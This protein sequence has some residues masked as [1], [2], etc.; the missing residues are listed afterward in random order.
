MAYPERYFTAMNE[1]L[2]ENAEWHFA[3]PVFS[4]NG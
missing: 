2:S 4:A 3:K 1:K